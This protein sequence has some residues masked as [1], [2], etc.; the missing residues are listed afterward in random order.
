MK[1]IFT[2]A[3]ADGLMRGIY[4]SCIEFLYIS[5]YGSKLSLDQ[6]F[7]LCLIGPVL[8]SIVTILLMPKRKLK[9]I[10][11]FV[12]ISFFFFVHWYI[13]IFVIRMICSLEFLP[14]RELSYA[15]GLVILFTMMLYSIFSALIRILIF[16]VYFV[17]AM[18]RWI[19]MK[20]QSRKYRI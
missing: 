12:I 9:E 3:M 16:A 5:I 18:V 4:L 13:V 19:K 14:L 6:H 8:S 2:N 20:I 7:I 17:L 1:K 11:F 10:L 15:D